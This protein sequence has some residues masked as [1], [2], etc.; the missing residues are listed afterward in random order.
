VISVGFENAG[1]SPVGADSSEVHAAKVR[2]AV[3]T[4]GATVHK[5]FPKLAKEEE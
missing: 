5:F 2:A 4:A 1:V 3:R